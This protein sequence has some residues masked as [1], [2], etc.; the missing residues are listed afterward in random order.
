MQGDGTAAFCARAQ[1]LLWVQRCTCLP[2]LMNAEATSAMT[3]FYDFHALNSRER[4]LCLRACQWPLRT[5]GQSPAS[6]GSQ[7]P[8]GRTCRGDSD[9]ESADPGAVGPGPGPGAGARVAL[10]RPGVH[11]GA[12]AGPPTGRAGRL[13]VGV[14]AACAAGWDLT[15]VTG[16]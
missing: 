1:R 4:R 3:Q 15:S 9:S 13:R 7:V 8:S 5:S 12:N 2:I 6:D 14:A 10:A 16:R 11:A